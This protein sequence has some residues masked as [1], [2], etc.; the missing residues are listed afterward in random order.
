MQVLNWM[1]WEGGVDLVATTTEVATLPNVILHVARMVHTPVGS[2]PAGLILFQPEPSG[3]PEIFG[4]VSP[5][6]DV[7]AYFGP[8]IF[9]GTP[10]ENAPYLEGDIEVRVDYPNSA[11]ARIDVAGRTFEVIFSG[12]GPQEMVNRPAGSPLPFAQTGLESAAQNVTVNQDLSPISIV[13][14]PIGISGGPAAVYAACGIYT[15]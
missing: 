11:F 1:S 10:F 3:D 5:D 4:F 9:A 15:R 6:P 7:A 8:H 14:P 12:L 2:A 13:V